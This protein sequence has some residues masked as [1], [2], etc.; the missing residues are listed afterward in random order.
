VPQVLVS[1]GV[2]Q[3]GNCSGL[4]EHIITH[5]YILN[6]RH[7]VETCSLLSQVVKMGTVEFVVSHLDVDIK[8][9]RWDCAVAILPPLPY[10]YDV[11]D[12]LKSAQSGVM[13][14]S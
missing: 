1:S 12:F 9:Q 4:T 8:A 14:R 11:S 6:N 3:F 13:Q 7:S 5:S 2:V 10:A